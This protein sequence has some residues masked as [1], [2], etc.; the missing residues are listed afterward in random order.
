MA[1]IIRKIA[2]LATGDEL[3][4]GDVLNTNS[5]VIAEQLFKHHIQPGLHA[6]ANDEQAEIEKAMRFL[7]ADHAGLII[8]GGLGPTSDDRTRF[9]LG[10]ILNTELIFDDACWQRVVERLQRLS[11]PVPDTNRQ[12]CLFPRGAVIFPNDNGTAAACQVMTGEKPVFLLP[13]PP[14]ECLPIFEK[15]VLPYLQAQGY[16]QPMFRCEWLLLGVSE[17]SV[18]A[19]LDPLMENSACTVGYRVNA[20]YLE[21][22]LQSAN[23]DALEKLRTEFNALIGQQSVSSQ[24]QKAS[25][26]LIEMILTLQIPINIT[27]HATG[28][29]LSATI[30]TP[31]T[32][33]YL[34]F[35]KPAANSPAIQINISGLDNYWRKQTTGDMASVVITY[36]GRRHH[37]GATVPSRQNRTLLYALEAICWEILRCLK[38]IQRFNSR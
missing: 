19:Q 34:H 8:T 31:D 5:Q 21:V 14:F 6:T 37:L 2:L 3:T 28:G 15:Q 4:N 7:L 16:A 29:L 9:A 18:A 35:D 1:E 13:G 12:Q 33:A 27:D 10:K 26:Q 23:R 30:L 24:K 36:E 38:V 20:P 11:L 32:Y 22:K 25:A 17:G